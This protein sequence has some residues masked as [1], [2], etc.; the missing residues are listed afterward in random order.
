MRV[1]VYVF[2]G[3]TNTRN[4]ALLKAENSVSLMTLNLNQKRVAVNGSTIGDW[5]V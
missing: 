2:D 3:N 5:G 1:R 4:K